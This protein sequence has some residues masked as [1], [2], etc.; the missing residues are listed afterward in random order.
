MTDASYTKLFAAVATAALGA[1]CLGS[2]YYNPGD[3]NDA[4]VNSEGGIITGKPD[5]AVDVH[6]EFDAKVRPI[7]LAECGQCHATASGGVGPGFLSA[8][9]DVY[10][11]VISY[12]GLIGLTPETSRILT[13]DVHVGPSFHAGADYTPSAQMQA[14][15]K[16]ISDWIV[17]Y[18]EAGG[19]DI[20]ADLSVKPRIMPFVPAA[21]NKSID[22]GILDPTLAGTTLS[23]DITMIGMTQIELSN[24]TLKGTATVGV[25]IKSPVVAKYAAADPNVALD[26]DYDYIGKDFTAGPG[27]TTV[28]SPSLTFTAYTAGQL[29]NVSFELLENSAGAPDM[30]GMGTTMCKDLNAWATIMPMFTTAQPGMNNA[31]AAGA[32]HGQNGGTGG[33]NLN[34]ISATNQAVCTSVLNN[35]I[36]ATPA[37]SPIYLHPTDASNHAGGKITAGQPRT[38]WL[39]AVTNFANAEK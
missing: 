28:F 23:F 15:A 9:P 1:G 6:A 35:T 3:N 34:G 39:T 4:G 27:V 22:L 21:G 32:C 8:N 31:C 25:H 38:D 36:V 14:E 13:K 20:G 7:L 19:H 12:P 11:T 10:T 24:I 33:M 30:A 17:L 26:I 29:I 5:M 18:N 37:Q 2:A 16:T